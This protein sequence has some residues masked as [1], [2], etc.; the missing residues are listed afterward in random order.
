MEDFSFILSSFEIAEA[1]D[2]D[3]MRIKCFGCHEGINEN[4][5]EFPRE[6]LQRDYPTLIDKSVFIAT[7]KDNKPTGHAFNFVSKQFDK[8]KRT[9]IGHIVNAYP[10]IV[11]SDNEIVLIQNF[12]ESNKINGEYRIICELVLDKAYEPEICETLRKLHE[13]GNLNF[14]M[15]CVA[16]Y[17]INE[18]GIKHC[19]NIHFIGL[20]VVKNPAF[21]N[22]YSIEV[23]EI[24]EDALVNFEEMYKEAQGKIENLVAEKTELKNAISEKEVAETNLREEIVALKATVAELE[25]NVESLKGYKTKVETAEKLEVGK[26]R[27]EKLEKYSSVTETAEQ[28]AELSQEDYL[29]KLETAV[30]SYTPNVNTNIGLSTAIEHAS[31]IE[32]KDNKTKLLEALSTLANLK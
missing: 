14:S 26:A 6:V 13:D 30:E 1:T 28:L 4:G 18:S 2:D 19:T 23:S 10:C 25:A 32:D 11:T 9:K 3:L 22:S 16:D 20:C 21:V 5:T 24:K 7:D 12:D 15:E 29:N 27:K 17:I 8:D 31:T